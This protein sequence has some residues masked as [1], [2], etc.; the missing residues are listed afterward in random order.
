MSSSFLSLPALVLFC[1]QFLSGALPASAQEVRSD[2]LLTVDHYLDYEQVS[3]PRISPD[4]KQVI[5]TRRWVNVL[6][7]KWDSGL[8]LMNMDGTHNRFLV[9]GSNATWSP[10]GSRIAYLA[11][12]EPKGTQIFVRWM[13]A[14]G[15]TSQI[16]RVTE[17]PANV[18]W[19][20][21]GRS[22]AFTMLLK[23]E[24][25]WKISMPAQP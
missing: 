20:P 6:E 4:G 11:D 3:D 15:A 17:T 14:E 25:P 16:T 5:Y 2:A 19:S 10:D 13:D 12:G 24:T 7:D 9:K 23:S 18:S 21:D 22:L 8:W 1:S